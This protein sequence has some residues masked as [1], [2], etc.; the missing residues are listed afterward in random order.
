MKWILREMS[1]SSF[2]NLILHYQIPVLHIPLSLLW[3]IFKWFMIIQLIRSINFLSA[4]VLQSCQNFCGSKSP[5]K[6]FQSNFFRALFFLALNLFPLLCCCW[7][8]L[9]FISQ[10]SQ[11]VG[12]DWITG[13][14]KKWSINIKYG[15]WGGCSSE[16]CSA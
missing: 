13:K 9:H 1:R 14:W 4:R 2:R 16:N 7:F 3:N 8:K 12:N 6:L 11:R 15:E 10:L 5:G